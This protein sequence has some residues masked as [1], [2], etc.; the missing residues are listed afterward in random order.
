[1]TKYKFSSEYEIHASPKRIYSYVHTANGLEQW[2]AT[3]V[4]VKGKEKVFNFVWDNED[5]FARI[6]AHRTNKLVKFEFISDEEGKSNYIEFRLE[7]NE[8]TDSTFLKVTDY[9]EMEDEDD[10][11][12]LWDGLVADLRE[13]VGG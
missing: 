3:K 12:G 13:V 4:E 9:S 1:M 2:F 10:L 6:V 11:N 8:M 7:H 5:H